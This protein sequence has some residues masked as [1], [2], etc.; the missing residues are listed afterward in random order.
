MTRTWAGGA[1]PSST[2][3]RRAS[4]ERPLES[5][6]RARHSVEQPAASRIRWERSGMVPRSPA[7][8]ALMRSRLVAV[9]VGDERALDDVRV[10]NVRHAKLLERAQAAQQ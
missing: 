4:R 10:T 2:A 7:R 9:L 8:T 5:A 6:I 1:P 3:T